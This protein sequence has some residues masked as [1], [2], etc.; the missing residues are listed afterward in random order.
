MS[1]GGG[2]PDIAGM[3]SLKVDCNG[4]VPDGWTADELRSKFEKFGE[5]GDIFVPRERYSDRP[6]PFA[7]VRFKN[8]D[9]ADEAIKEMQ[10]TR[11][12]G[13]TLNVS[14]A[15]KSREEAREA[16]N[17]KQNRSRSRG[18]YRGRSP[19]RRRGGRDSRSR[20][21]GRGGRGRDRRR[22]PSSPRRQ[23]AVSGS[24]SRSPSRRRRR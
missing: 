13:C 7:F 2:L 15:N 1:R 11:M 24:R 4:E 16:T 20:S 3:T 6:R 5:I 14:K 12:D 22:S 10:G 19:P 18:G 9:D 8:E 21:R 23:R 17:R